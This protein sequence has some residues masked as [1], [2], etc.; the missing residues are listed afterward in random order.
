MTNVLWPGQG[1][2][3]GTSLTSPG[4][5][6][7]LDLQADGNLVVYDW[8]FS[9]RAIWSS[10]TNGQPVS[11]ANMQTDGEL[12]DLRLPRGH[13]VDRDRRGQERIPGSSG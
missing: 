10:G 5:R 2:T 3:P 12:R 9:H 13:L 11:S 6:Y 1:L 4:G 7:E 8:W